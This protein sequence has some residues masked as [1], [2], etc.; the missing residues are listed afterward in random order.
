MYR[1]FTSLLCTLPPIAFPP[2]SPPWFCHHSVLST[3]SLTLLLP[4]L[5]SCSAEPRP[6]LL[7]FWQAM[8]PLPVQPCHPVLLTSCLLTPPSALWFLYILDPISSKPDVKDELPLCAASLTATISECSNRRYLLTTK[9]NMSIFL[10]MC[11][12]L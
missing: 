8:L 6:M 3:P 5:Y 11:T 2:S 9:Q 10:L 12:T 4:D 1:I 7:C